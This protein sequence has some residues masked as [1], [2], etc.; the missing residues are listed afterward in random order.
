ML[1]KPYKNKEVHMVGPLNGAGIFKASR[2][3]ARGERGM[4]Q[5]QM[6]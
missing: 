3:F 6:Y 1:R 2:D 5:Y 4:K